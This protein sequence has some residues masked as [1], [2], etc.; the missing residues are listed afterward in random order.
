MSNITINTLSFNKQAEIIDLKKAAEQGNSEAITA[1]IN[2][3][4][5]SCSCSCKCKK[6]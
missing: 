3:R 5:G 1:L 6:K 2:L 4:G